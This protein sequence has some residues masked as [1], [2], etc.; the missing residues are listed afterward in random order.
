MNYQ[1]KAIQLE[2]AAARKQ[3][4]ASLLER[5]CPTI[6]QQIDADLATPVLRLW[7]RSRNVDEHAHV[8]VVNESICEVLATMSGT[9]FDGVTGHAGIQ[10][11]YGYLLSTVETPYG[12]K[13]D[14]WVEP[15]IEQGLGIDVPCLRPAPHFG[16][17]LGNLTYFIGRVA[18]RKC[19][20]ELAI[21]RQMRSQ[22]A[23]PL[24]AYPFRRLKVI[25]VVEQTKLVNRHLVELITDLVELPHGSASSSHLVVYSIND[26]RQK[27]RQLITAFAMAS[28]AIADLIL[29]PAGQIRIRTR[30]NSFVK[31][32]AKERNGTRFFVGRR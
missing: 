32:F 21:L 29:K 1:A 19:E 2:A 15:T 7:G 16:T 4:T 31:G 3:L 8:A 10:H 22:V 14:R 12:M 11:T 23:E 25:R 30:Y 20:R 27:N 18:F 17:L 26:S 5:C 13:R 28:T 24:L 9:E 6:G